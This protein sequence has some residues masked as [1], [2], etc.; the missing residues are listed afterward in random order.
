[1]I[2]A[3]YK[4]FDELSPSCFNN[5]FLSVEGCMVEVIKS[6]SIYNTYKLGHL[7]KFKLVCTGI[8]PTTLKC[9]VVNV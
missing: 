7:G 1:M 2:D 4:Y 3:V 6:F 8:L 9:D 5:V